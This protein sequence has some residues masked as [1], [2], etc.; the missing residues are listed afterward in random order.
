[1]SSAL[2]PETPDKEETHPLTHTVSHFGLRVGAKHWFSVIFLFTGK[3][4]VKFVDI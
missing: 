3:L 1:M 2:L 4:T